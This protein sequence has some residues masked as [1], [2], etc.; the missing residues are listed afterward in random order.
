MPNEHVNPTENQGLVTVTSKGTTIQAS[1][2]DIV[3]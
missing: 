1:E 3:E 2:T